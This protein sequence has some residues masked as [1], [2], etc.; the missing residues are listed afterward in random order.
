MVKVVIVRCED[1]SDSL[2]AAGEALH[3]L[4]PAG[5]KDFVRP[6]ETVFLKVN[7]LSAKPPG[8]A[9]TTHPEFVRAVARL[10][11]DAGG[12]P[13]IGDSSGGLRSTG[14][15]LEKSGMTDVAGELKVPLVNL[16]DRP[17]RREIHGAKVFKR[18]HMGAA[19]FEADAIFSL[20]KLKTHLL[21]RYTGAVKNLYGTVT[22]ADK[23]LG[24]VM[25]PSPGRFT[26]GLLDIYSL[27][28]PR[29]AI[30]DGIIGMEGL[31]PSGGRPRKAG[32]VLASPDS[33]ALDWVACQV[34]GYRPVECYLFEAAER[35]RIMPGHIEIVGESITDVSVEFK[36]PFS[37]WNFLGRLPDGFLRKLHRMSI[38][39]NLPRIS[40]KRCTG[41]RVCEK[42]CPTGAITIGG[43]GERSTVDRKKCIRCY[44]CHELCPYD[45]VD[46]RTFGLKWK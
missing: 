32:V 15:A 24:H 43:E 4:S 6:G 35:R 13:V 16:D 17:V 29:L 36:K 33:L 10:V 31:G 44:C 25:A 41:C 20:P 30:M 40:M 22:G 38:S 21:T 28:R 12:L 3:L 19:L 18:F 9:V 2:R 37:R 39:V 5:M 11:K 27:V 26:E 23:R 1:Y 46:I 8:A 14:V 45:A 42:N 34:I 7:A